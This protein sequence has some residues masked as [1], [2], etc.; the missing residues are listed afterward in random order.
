MNPL[1]KVK[2]PREGHPE[3]GDLR[4]DEILL[5][6]DYTGRFAIFF[7][8][9]GA[10]IP[11]MYQF[12]DMEYFSPEHFA[13]A[14]EATGWECHG[15]RY[16]GR[17][18]ESHRRISEIGPEIETETFPNDLLEYTRNPSENL[19]RIVMN[20]ERRMRA[21]YDLASFSNN[22]H[23][24]YASEELYEAGWYW[25]HGNCLVNEDTMSMVID[26]WKKKTIPDI[27]KELSGIV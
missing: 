9:P 22:E 25:V 26:A 23:G 10:E 5:R 15:V 7:S 11:K 6:N 2:K 18:P 17:D 24:M 14:L 1:I 20:A 21:F 8:Y 16:N 12:P 13:W 27:L 19:D 4:P 3:I